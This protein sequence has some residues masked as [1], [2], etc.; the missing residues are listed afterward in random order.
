LYRASGMTSDEFAQIA[1]ALT[2]TNGTYIEGRVN[3]NAAS[4]AVLQCLP[5]ISDSPDLAQTLTD[6]RQSNPDKLTSVGWVA[7]ALGQNNA[8]TLNTLQRQDCITT[9]SYQF[10]ADVVAL[11][12]H[13]R[14]YRRVKFIFD[15]VDGSP[16]IV[17]RQDLTNLGWALGKELRQT[18]LIA[19]DTR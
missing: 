18:W 11:G 5:G 19:K 6:Y 2:T 1:N 16:K 14:G 15:T 17:Y 10:A 3:V 9:Q 13:G 4:L 7:D 12:P 8:S